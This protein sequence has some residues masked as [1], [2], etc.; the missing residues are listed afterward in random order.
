MTKRIISLLTVLS[1]LFTPLLRADSSCEECLPEE[2]TCCIEEPT[3]CEEEEEERICTGRMVG[4]AS[5]DRLCESRR[6][7]FLSWGL[8]IGVVVIGIATLILVGH[9]HKK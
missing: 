2:P 7:K 5:E 3:C 1:I 4:R 8:A 6:R 9:H